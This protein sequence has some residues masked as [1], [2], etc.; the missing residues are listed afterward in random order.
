MINR[1]TLLGRVGKDPETREFENGGIA[2]FSLATSE[3]WKNKD[4]EWQEKTE[5]HNI[6]YRGKGWERISER[7]SKGTLLYVEG[8]IVTRKWQD[9]EGRDRYTTEVSSGFIRVV[10]KGT[11]QGKKE[12]PS[13]EPQQ[14]EPVTD[15]HDT[16]DDLPF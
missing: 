9:K 3:N 5:W 12:A 1:V 16:G 10:D 2:T 4:G 7:V 15:K 8:K 13:D 14:K 11:Q 6:V